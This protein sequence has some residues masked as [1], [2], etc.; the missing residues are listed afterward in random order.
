MENVQSSWKH[1]IMIVEALV[2]IFPSLMKIN[3]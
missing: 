3:F 1:E 2:F